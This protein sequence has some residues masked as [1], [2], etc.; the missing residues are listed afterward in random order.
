M[1]LSWVSPDLTETRD[2]PFVPAWSYPLIERLPFVNKPGY[3]RSVSFSL[4]QGMYTPEE[5]ERNDLIADARPY[6]GMTYLAVGVHGKDDGRMD[7]LEFDV[8][9][10]GR[11]SYVEEVQKV[12]HRWVAATDP[13]GW[14]HQLRDE[15]ILNAFFERKWRLIRTKDAASDSTVSLT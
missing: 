7:T 13:Q 12:T 14:N 10:I 2:T 1:K 11:H 4:G 15:P 5:I 3:R 6:A 9:I 8:G